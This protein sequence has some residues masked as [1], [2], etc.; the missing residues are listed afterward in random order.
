M[1]YPPVITAFM[2]TKLLVNAVF[3]D[4]GRI[5]GWE[6]VVLHMHRKKLTRTLKILPSSG[7]YRYTLDSVCGCSE[8][9]V[10]RACR[11]CTV[12][13]LHTNNPGEKRSPVDDNYV[14]PNCSFL[15]KNWHWNVWILLPPTALRL[16]R[17]WLLGWSALN[18]SDQRCVV[19]PSRFEKKMSLL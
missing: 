2:P 6:N 1:L 19:Q 14:M 16:F 11:W 8:P 5:L 9:L 13:A 4:V 18:R 7:K 17:R 10:I 3:S 12:N 15:L